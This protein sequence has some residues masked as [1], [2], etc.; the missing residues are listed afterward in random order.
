MLHGDV[1][2]QV[3]VFLAHPIEPG[4]LGGV[5][6]GVEPLAECRQ[7]AA[8]GVVALLA[9]FQ[10]FLERRGIQVVLIDEPILGVEEAQE[11]AAFG[12]LEHLETLRLHRTYVSG[13]GRPS[14]VFRYAMR[15]R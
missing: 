6:P 12:L 9:L 10:Q 4:H 14:G 3:P 15:S 11:T 8:A 5:E 1:Q 13:P 2:T 7:G